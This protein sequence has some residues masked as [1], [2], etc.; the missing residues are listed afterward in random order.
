MAFSIRVKPFIDD[1]LN[2]TE[3]I[4]ELAIWMTTIFLCGFL[5]TSSGI[6]AAY[7]WILI[8]LICGAMALNIMFMMSGTFFL[9]RH[10]CRLR[11]A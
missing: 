4:N 2:W 7:G 1:K 5:A 6:D 3:M 8:A 11:I 10:K 9:C